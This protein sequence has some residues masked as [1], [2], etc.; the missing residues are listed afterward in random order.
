MGWAGS[1]FSR[2]PVEILT[3]IAEENDETMTRLDAEKYR[4]EFVAERTA[5]EESNN[6]ENFEVVRTRICLA[7]T[8]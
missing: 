2:L 7:S 5:F 4:E 6:K 8:T 3:M 1:L